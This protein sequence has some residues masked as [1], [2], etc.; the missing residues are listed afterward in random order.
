MIDSQ[1][2]HE[3]KLIGDLVDDSKVASPSAV[4]SFQVEPEGSPD[5]MWVLRQT[6]IHELDAGGRDLLG[7]TIE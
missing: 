2:P 3:M 5:P 4:L 6:P 1:D 7:Q